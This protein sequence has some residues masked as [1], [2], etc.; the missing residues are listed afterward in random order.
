MGRSKGGLNHSAADSSAG[1][2]LID[3]PIALTVLAHLIP[4]DPQ[5]RQL[6]DRELAGQRRGH[7]TRG[8]EVA[9][10]GNRDRALRCPLR[11]PGW[12][13]RGSAYRNT[14]RLDLTPEDTSPG[15]EALG[16]S[17]GLI[18]GHDT[19]REALPDCAG[20]VI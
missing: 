18:V 1:R 12:E 17:L 10:S 19:S 16:Q 2:D 8:G 6:A 14:H 7:W 15:V 3:A 13:D 4:D 20:Q 9:A 5:H 11:S